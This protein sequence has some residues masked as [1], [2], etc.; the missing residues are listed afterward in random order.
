[1]VSRI[2]GA[3]ALGIGWA[4]DRLDPR[5][6]PTGLWSQAFREGS[7][8]LLRKIK[9]DEVLLV[10]AAG[11]APLSGLFGQMAG[12]RSGPETERKMGR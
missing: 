4:V 1:M 7:P 6:A 2:V 10:F 8:D 11:V 5:C 9:S 12:T 3:H